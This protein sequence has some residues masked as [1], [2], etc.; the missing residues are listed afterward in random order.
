MSL[1]SLGDVFAGTWRA[2]R[3][4]IGRLW[5]APQPKTEHAPELP[6]SYGTTRVVLLVIDPYTVHAYWEVAPKKLAEARS[7]IRVDRQP[8]A[9]LRFHELN[10]GA[11]FDV[12]VDLESRNWYIPL[13]DAGRSYNVELGLRAAEGEFVLLAKSNSAQTPRAWPEIHVEEH[14][15]SVS[16]EQIEIVPPPI[17]RKPVLAHLPFSARRDQPGRLFTF[18]LQQG[19]L[20]QDSSASTP[21]AL[22]E[23]AEK[24]FIAGISSVVPHLPER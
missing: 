2:A 6:S 23:L 24:K 20:R 16:K 7:R 22:A 8:R 3:A 19:G 15:M 18:D 12:E 5:A 10:D 1:E 11:S 14:F 21:L 17:Y 13:Q 9:V 4:F